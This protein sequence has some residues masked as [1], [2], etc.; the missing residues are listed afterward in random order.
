M[1]VVHLDPWTDIIAIN[2]GSVR[3]LVGTFSIAQ[4]HQVPAGW[5]YANAVYEGWPGGGGPYLPPPYPGGWIGLLDPATYTPTWCGQHGVGY[6]SGGF[7]P[8]TFNATPTGSHVN[9]SFT[10]Y[11]PSGQSMGGTGIVAT[12]NVPSGILHTLANKAAAAY[13]P[14]HRPKWVAPFLTGPAHPRAT[15]TYLTATWTSLT[16]RQIEWKMLTITSSPTDVYQI[17]TGS[18]DLGGKIGLIGETAYTHTLDFSNMSAT[19]TVG[20]EPKTFRCTGSIITNPA[21]YSVI[22]SPNGEV[23]NTMSALLLLEREDYIP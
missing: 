17:A 3:Y 5:V 4:A 18:G 10:K 23:I 13:H 21:G 12:S 6:Y 22:F 16:I 14:S 1:A 20:G 7:G 15:W 19:I 11:S 9:R 2:M 8:G